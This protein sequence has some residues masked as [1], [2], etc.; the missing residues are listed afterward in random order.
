MIAWF[1]KNDVAA[2]ILLVVI[3]LSGL[4]FMSAKVPVDMF[5]EI[6]IRNVNVNMSLPGASPQEVEEGITIKIEEAVQDL[7]G[8]RQ[9][10][11]RS[12]EGSASIS[13]EVED[14]YDV[15]ELLDDVKIRVD[16]VSNFPVDAENLRIQI[17]QRRRDAM[18]VVLYGD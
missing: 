6:E 10:T 14:G 4:Y 15:R 1:A 16:S 5:P 9:M 7:E 3:M 11:S 2:N 8:I 18:G 12:R 13:I 17:P